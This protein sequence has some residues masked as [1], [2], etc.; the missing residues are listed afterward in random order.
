MQTT[1]KER[2]LIVDD[3]NSIIEIVRE[4]LEKQNYHVFAASHGHEAI[5]L[6][7]ETVP[8][9]DLVILDLNLPDMNGEDVLDCLGNINP[10]VKV[11][12]SSGHNLAEKANAM[13]QKGVRQFLQKPF[14]IA[15]L[16]T[17]VRDALTSK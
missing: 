3:E 5:L 2:I 6:Y 1:G 4:V 17:K 12:L 8:P 16:S 15:E 10:H 7:R 9:I 14:R 13:V 11:I